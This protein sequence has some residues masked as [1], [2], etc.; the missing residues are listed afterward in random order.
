M[1]Y[2]IIGILF[3]IVLLVVCLW[4]SK[5]IFDAVINSDLS[6]FWKYILLK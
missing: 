1:K 4:V 6:P 3:T 5:A 2:E